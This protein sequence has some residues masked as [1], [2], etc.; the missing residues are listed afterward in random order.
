M[1]MEGTNTVD[2]SFELGRENVW[3]LVSGRGVSTSRSQESAVYL[4]DKK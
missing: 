3:E 1:C 4:G 2:V